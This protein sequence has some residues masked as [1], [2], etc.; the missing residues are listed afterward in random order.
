MRMLEKCRNNKHNNNFDH[1]L[2]S[3]RTDGGKKLMMNSECD[4]GK[5]IPVYRRGGH[6][7]NSKDKCAFFNSMQI[8]Q[9]LGINKF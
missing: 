8:N 4:A 5:G 6:Q 9:C 2:M 7:L 1:P 3:R